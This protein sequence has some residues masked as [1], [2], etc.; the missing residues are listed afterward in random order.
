MA[1]QTLRTVLVKY[2][3]TNSEITNGNY[4][5]TVTPFSFLDFINNTQADYSPEEYSSFYSSYLQVW[6][7][8]QNASEE[9]QK[10]QFKDYYRQFIKE[11]VL[12]YTTETE[13][14]FLEKINFNDPADLDVAIP[15]FANRLKDIALF[16]KKK[17]DEGK[18]VI[19]RN[20]IKGSKTGLEKAIFDNIYNF[21]FNT[22]DSLDTTNNTVFAAVEGLGVE[23]EEFVDVYGDYFDL[24]DGSESNN[25]NEI[26][27]KYYLDPQGIEA[28]TGEENFLGAIRSFKINPQPIT[29][30]EFDAICNPDNELVQLTNQY[31]TGG[32]TISEFYA[33]KRLLI[34]KFI[35]TDIYY[36][37]TSTTPATSGLLLTADNPAAN[38]LN[39]QGADAAVVESN[40]VKL[41]RDVG[42][43]FRPDDIGLFKLQS[44]NFNYEINSSVLAA[45]QFYIFPDP[46]KFGNVSTNPQSVYPVYYKFDYRDNTRNVSSGLAAGD[47]K[48]T[49][50]VTTFESYT[51]K[52]RNN[53][54]LKDHND[55]S[56]NLN[57]TD[58]YNEG[59]VDKYQTDIYGNEY[60][61]FKYETLKP[62]D[63]ESST[64]IKNLLLDGHVFFDRFEGYN[65]NFALT[66]Q[67]G[68]T[69]KSGMELNTN[70][71]DLEGF[72]TLY[73]REFYP[74]QDL[75]EDTRN[76]VPFWR[77]GG[78]FTFLDGSELPNP[79]TG[80]G[81]G[82]PASTN[83]YYT[84][85][86][87]GTFPE[88]V[89]L[90]T[91]QVPLSDITTEA[92]FNLIAENSDL[93][94]TQ[95]VKYYLSAGDPYTNYDGGH[96]EDN[97][98]LPNDFNYTDNLRFLDTADSRG[99]TVLSNL[100]SSTNILTK[101]EKKS[102]S[103]KLY[104]K[105]GTYSTS[106]PI[107]AALKGTISK[108]SSA[109]QDQVNHELVD[110]DIIQNTIFIE[111]K[112]NLIVDKIAYSDNEF[113]KPSTVNT[114]FS[115]NS[116]NGVE[117]FTN[118]FYVEETGKIYFA[119]FR[120]DSNNTC[121][122]IPANFAAVYPEIYEYSII[123]N[124]SRKVYPSSELDSSLS[125]FELNEFG[126]TTRNY[127]PD[128]V[129]TP[130]IAYNSRNDLFKVTYIVN[131]MNDFSHIVDVSFTM[132]DNKL[133]VNDSNRYETLNNITRT[134]TFGNFTTF[135][136]I[137]A[138]G[139]NYTRDVD[140]FTL[141]V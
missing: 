39:L 105:N 26:E 51:T 23:I 125:A 112:S 55:I 93:N 9:E 130:K 16:Y 15:F 120:D 116:A 135:G 60:A 34:S 79:L 131:D 119:R 133:V 35:G 5:D 69:F 115:V 62:I 137:S 61:L 102:I 10:T 95:D 109:I 57:F 81:P 87:E 121:E 129:H 66:G 6:H 94:F 42:L 33:L 141:T 2:S 4:R 47:P 107:S 18:Y 30:Q 43:N 78:A 52:E 117:T 27:T 80:I 67:S 65:F 101:E 91:D 28:I 56:Y 86:A 53:T 77:D 113:V 71:Y 31:E 103:G 110:F 3:I 24:P 45:D 41:L 44:E 13:K 97:V 136:Q 1:N 76:L 122:N 36:V 7:S 96:F 104:V 50:K 106:E 140:N 92:E 138:S 70:G 19:D 59:L 73:M 22:E 21:V 49:N 32:I 54:H 63:E 134:S 72:L 132:V 139:G 64:E 111:T 123:D 84:V 12:N 29:P 85:L 126:A 20:K 17:R 83:Y 118:R 124:T 37:D 88:D 89:N 14:R 75:I 38:A 8:K 98:V 48:V 74:Y 25:I 46:A 82:Y 128:S 127:A 100:S 11:I 99:S 40:Q 58:L 68:N 90:T 108:Y 114:F